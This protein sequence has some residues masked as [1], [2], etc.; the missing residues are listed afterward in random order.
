MVLPFDNLNRDQTQ[1]YFCDGLTS[2]ITTDLSKFSNL[3]VIASNTAFTY[4]GRAVKIQ[5]VSRD[6]NVRYV[7]EGS[8]QKAAD[9]VRV[10]AQLIDGASGHHV[11]AE[12][13]DRPISDLLDVQDDIIHRIVSALAVRLTMLER[14]RVMQK[15]PVDP[16]AY[17]LYLQG[18]HAYSLEDRGKF[19]QCRKLF[20]LATELDPSFARAWGYLSYMT[21]RGAVLG[22]LPALAMAEAEI[23][24]KKAIQLDP[25]DYANYWDMAFIH[26]H[27]ERYNQA[28]EE[29][30][31]AL[32][33][34]SN[35]ADLLAE[36][37]DLYTSL[38]QCEKAI[39]QI[40]ML[41]ASTQMSPTCID[42]TWV[43]H[44]TMPGSMIEP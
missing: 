9:R 35:D 3:L 40:E 14:E 41:C 38:G 16:T 37:A 20:E 6:L 13:F 28:I 36:V 18:V 1:D 8:V 31:K 17:E 10:N 30:E 39:D 21:A 43:G 33:L 44:C 29:Y 25:Y 34:N 12:R 42:G 7:L 27:R 15:N 2:D 24:A 22:W 11:W 19:E 5:D 4:K 32:R 26:F 23:L